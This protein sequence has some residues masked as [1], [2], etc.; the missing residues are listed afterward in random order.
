[1]SANWDGIV[2]D[3]PEGLV[4]IP[5]MDPT[6]GSRAHVQPLIDGSRTIDDLL[7]RLT[8]TVER[9]DPDPGW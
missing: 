3:T 5:M 1:V 2:V 6:K 9:M 7:L 8:G 4:R